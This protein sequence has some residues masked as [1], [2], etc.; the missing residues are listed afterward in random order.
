MTD[1]SISRRKE[2][3]ERCKYGASGGSGPLS[4]LK[5]INCCTN[6]NVGQR[7]RLEK[8]QEYIKKVEGS[9]INHIDLDHRA[10]S[11]FGT[12]AV[13]VLKPEANFIECE[14]CHEYKS[15]TKK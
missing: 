12:T 6:I 9:S 14:G 7:W 8:W 13:Y 10:Q 2:R 15:K 4:S 11:R 1:K 3:W 5:S